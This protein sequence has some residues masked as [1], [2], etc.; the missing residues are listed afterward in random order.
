MRATHAVIVLATL[1]LLAGAQAVVPDTT[2]ID[3]IRCDLFA[4]IDASTTR[5]NPQP[6]LATI[7]RLSFHDCVG[8]CDGFIDTDLHGN[9]GLADTIRTVNEMYD[10]LGAPTG[11]SRADFYA[12]VGTLAVH[13]AADN[14]Q[15]PT[16]PMPTIPL[17]FGRADG[18]GR[19]VDLPNPHNGIEEVTTVMADMFGFTEREAVAIM[20]AHTLGRAHRGASGFN[21]PWTSRPHTL[22]ND[23]F[24]ELTEPWRVVESPRGPFRSFWRRVTG[25]P[26][27]R[28][29]L[30]VDIALTNVI[31]PT[32]TGDRAGEVTACRDDH[33]DCPIQGSVATIATDFAND[34]AAFIAAFATAFT[35]MITRGPNGPLAG[36]LEPAGGLAYTLP[37][38]DECA[39]GPP[40]PGPG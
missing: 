7:V 32:T 20:G 4:R 1:A 11:M 21:G 38:N 37:A 39:P 3:A 25:G 13:K 12:L 2:E 31:S 24:S 9:E 40:G 6:L 18:E 35:T 36:T 10:S 30:N 17:F 28:L 22:D 27:N 29:M 16:A 5:G 15:S 33:Q 14:Q 19:I 26:R 8:G 34:N 23:Y